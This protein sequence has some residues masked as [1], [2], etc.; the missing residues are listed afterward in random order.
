MKWDVDNHTSSRSLIH[1]AGNLNNKPAPRNDH[2]TQPKTEPALNRFAL[3]PLV[4]V[5]YAHREES[6]VGRR[7][8]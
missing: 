8:S 4:L 5:C 2:T 1:P 6:Y 3:K 7:L